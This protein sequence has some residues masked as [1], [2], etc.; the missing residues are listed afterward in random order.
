MYSVVQYLHYITPAST[1]MSF[2]SLTPQIDKVTARQTIVDFLTDK[3]IAVD[4]EDFQKPWGG[5]FTINTNDLNTFIDA[6]FP[7]KAEL[8]QNPGQLQPKIL[9]VAPKAR[10]SWQYHFRR[11][12]MWKVLFGPVGV[13][14]S[15]TDDQPEPK[16][17]NTGELIQHDK[18]VRHRLLGAENWGVVAEIWQ[19]TD[20]N[21]LSDEEDIVRV[22][23]DYG[24]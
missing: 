22:Q 13:V 5:Y 19:H 24:R 10:L 15:S 21:Q 6:F 18:E 9:L 2:T 3:H 16:F 4:Q 17:Y 11:A 1:I 20:P 23:D 8:K 12:E 7:E 14:Q